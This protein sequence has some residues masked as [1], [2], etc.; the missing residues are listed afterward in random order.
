LSFDPS[1]I[2]FFPHSIFFAFTLH[3]LSHSPSKNLRPTVLVTV[4][5]RYKS[6]H[7]LLL[8]SF[9]CAALMAN[10]VACTAADFVRCGAVEGGGEGRGACLSCRGTARVAPLASPL[11]SKWRLSLSQKQQQWVLGA[12]L[13]GRWHG[14]RLPRVTTEGRYLNLAL[15][16]SSLGN[17]CRRERR[18]RRWQTAADN[19]GLGQPSYSKEGMNRRTGQEVAED[20]MGGAGG[21]GAAGGGGWGGRG[22]WRRN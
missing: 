1:P 16:G 2:L 3:P 12:P 15:E 19:Y 22:L 13:K 10:A 18:G 14:N 6:C 4:S 21:G 8:V 17:A 20:Q 11:W 5:I 7:F 9:R